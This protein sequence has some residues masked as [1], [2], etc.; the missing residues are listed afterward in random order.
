MVLDMILSSSRVVII[1]SEMCVDGIAARRLQQ[2]MHPHLPPTCGAFLLLIGAVHL[3]TAV[4][5]LEA[6]LHV[7]AR[8][9]PQLGR[10]RALL[11]GGLVVFMRQA[12]LR[13]AFAALNGAA[14]RWVRALIGFHGPPAA[15]PVP[16]TGMRSAAMHEI[17]RTPVMKPASVVESL[18]DLIT[19]CRNGQKGF[20]AC[21]RHARAP[22]SKS[23]FSTCAAECARAAEEPGTQVRSLGGTAVAAL[24]AEGALRDRYPAAA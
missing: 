20:V 3:G 19:I 13:L 14:V 15:N 6:A 24:Q 18:N 11:V 1:Y 2:K 21:A 9:S 22:E 23:V 4:G 5:V 10:R 12:R 17:R 7:A 16:R 8:L